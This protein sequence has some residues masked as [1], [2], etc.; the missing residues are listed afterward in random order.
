MAG[1]LYQSKPNTPHVSNQPLKPC[2]KCGNSREVVGGVQVRE[3]WYCSQCWIK[4]IN[5]R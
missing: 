2:D 4:L 1:S 3:K 5:S